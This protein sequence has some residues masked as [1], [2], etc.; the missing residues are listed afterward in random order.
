MGSSF[1]ADSASVARAVVHGPGA[2]S[3]G[4]PS[5]CSKRCWATSNWS[6][7]TAASTGARSPASGSRSTCTIPSSSSWSIPARNCLALDGSRQRAM[8][9]WEGAKAGTGGQRTGSSA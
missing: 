3:T 1:R 2:S 7:P 9:K 5:S 6:G 4:A 8:R